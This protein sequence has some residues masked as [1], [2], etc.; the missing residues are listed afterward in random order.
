MSFSRY[1]SDP[2][3]RGNVLLG[4][5]RALPRIREAIARGQLAYTEMTLK[6]GQ[7]LDHIAGE[8]YNDGRLWWVIAAASNIGWWL[9]APPGTVLRIPNDLQQVADLL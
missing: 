2:E 5:A 7:R 1:K 6:E 3:I 9:Q 4:T 8:L